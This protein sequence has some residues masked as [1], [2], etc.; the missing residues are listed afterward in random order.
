MRTMRLV[1]FFLFFMMPGLVLAGLLGIP[2]QNTCVGENQEKKEGQCCEG[3]VMHPDTKKCW[4][5]PSV[6]VN[7]KMCQK[8][9]EC[10]KGLG[11]YVQGADDLF[12]TN[13]LDG[14]AKEDAMKKQADMQAQQE[15]LNHKPYEDGGKCA[16]DYECKSYACNKESNKCYTPKI[17]R[18]AR[19]GEEAPGEVQ[20]ETSLVKNNQKKCALTADDANPTF[21]GI[22][23]DVSFQSMPKCQ[24]EMKPDVEKLANTAR[25]SLR[26]MEF[27][28]SQARGLEGKDC[29]ETMPALKAIA[30][31]FNK[32]RKEIVK[33]FNIEWI[34]LENEADLIE[35]ARGTDEGVVTVHGLEVSKKDLASRKLSGHDTLLI[36]SRRNQLFASL[37]GS[38]MKLVQETAVKWTELSKQMEQYNEWNVKWTVGKNEYDGFFRDCRGGGF[39]SRF[40]QSFVHN[41]WGHYYDVWVTTPNTRMADSDFMVSYLQTISNSVDN[42]EYVAKQQVRDDLIYGPQ[43]KLIYDWIKSNIGSWYITFFNFDGWLKG[44]YYLIDPLLPGVEFK[45][46]GTNWWFEWFFHNVHRQ[47]WIGLDDDKNNLYAIR[48]AFRNKLV[49]YYKSMRPKEAKDPFI[50]EPEL[51]SLKA[52]DCIEKPKGENCNE[53]EQYLDEIADVVFAQHWAYSAHLTYKYRNY[54]THATSYRRRL[55]RRMEVEFST[56]DNFYQTVLA[57]RDRQNFCLDKVM[58]GLKDGGISTDEAGGIGLDS[59]NYGDN[60]KKP[61][62]TGDHKRKS[63]PLPTFASGKFTYNLST[64]TLMPLQA[65]QLDN[66]GLANKGPSFDTA[67]VFSDPLASAAMGARR[68]EMRAA[69][70]KAR[71]AGV[72]V[73]GQEKALKEAISKTGSSISKSGAGVAGATSSKASGLA[74][75]AFGGKATLDTV[76]NGGAGGNGP[77]GALGSTHGGGGHGGTSYGGGTS[78]SSGS[79]SG[80]SPTGSYKD[81][82]G[83][84]DEDKDAMLAN[85]ER[86]RSKYKSEE[87]DD[88]F[89]ILSKA[90]IRNLDKVLMRKKI[91]D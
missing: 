63:H 80:G 71:K 68:E 22:D 89:G 75:K 15:K 58:Q 44:G 47:K 10:D 74:N 30:E 7:R 69:N 26:G 84:S 33:N 13:N 20:C 42:G 19:L 18:L 88:L 25:K 46:H 35:K 87:G 8:T 56:L 78:Y 24:F 62:A 77:Q 38:M 3:L 28:F 14:K 4:K 36:M 52:R 29:L 72:N 65:G 9:E 23:S 53:F 64:G 5:D 27:L 12:S 54:F 11:C 48:Q 76:A 59:G 40:F 43:K 34:N 6:G 79:S 82:S 85:Y 86:N 21:P 70:A 32:Q 67:S 90:Y 16:A 81:H 51:I 61:T 2:E 39:F 66:Q 37:E 45:D 1:A 73:D 57:E 49:D 50:Y 17:C 91:E 31:E 60:D 41:R 55:F 83:M